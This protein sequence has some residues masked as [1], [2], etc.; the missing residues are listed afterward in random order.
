MQ[1]EEHRLDWKG[2]K[3]GA[4]GR[5]RRGSLGLWSRGWLQLGLGVA[6]Q[7]KESVGE[8]R[9]WDTSVSQKGLCPG[10]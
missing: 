8:E 3:G 5:Q 1:P 4:Q 6:W 2:C 9:P 7:V 10:H